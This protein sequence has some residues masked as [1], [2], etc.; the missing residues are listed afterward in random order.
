MQ[1]SIL[2][3]TKNI[4]LYLFSGK[5][6]F[7]S[8]CL[9]HSDKFKTSLFMHHLHKVVCIYHIYRPLQNLFFHS[10]K[11]LFFIMSSIW[12]SYLVKHTWH[13]AL[14]NLL[15]LSLFSCIHHTYGSS[16]RSRSSFLHETI[17]WPHL[18]RA[19]FHHSWHCLETHLPH[20]PHKHSW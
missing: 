15:E 6:R 2:P 13:M 8:P 20:H 10:C 5:E 9:G 19:L 1:L 17:L 4:H 12:G 7:D 11:S 18:L 3:K 16:S 14:K